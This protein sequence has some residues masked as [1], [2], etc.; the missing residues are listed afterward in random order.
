MGIQV[1]LS[2]L[3]WKY[4]RADWESGDGNR[5]ELGS[6]SE[7]VMEAFRVIAVVKE[8]RGERK[9]AKARGCHGLPSPGNRSKA[10]T[11]MQVRWGSRIGQRQEL[12][13]NTVV[14]ETSANPTGNSELGWSFR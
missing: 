14:L 13:C 2:T 12:N 7:T 6:F 10:E 5:K 4:N 1:K 3:L 9:E 11:G 8:E